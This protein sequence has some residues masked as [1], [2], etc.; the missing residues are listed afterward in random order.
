MN[1]KTLPL[2]F[3]VTREDKR[4]HSYVMLVMALLAGNMNCLLILVAYIP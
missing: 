2:D 3:D 4:I 1:P